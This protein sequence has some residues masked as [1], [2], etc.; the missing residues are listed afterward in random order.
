MIIK[1]L[2][3][4]WNNTYKLFRRISLGKVMNPDCHH[5]KSRGSWKST[6]PGPQN[7]ISVRFLKIVIL[8]LYLWYPVVR[9]DFLQVW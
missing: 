8:I 3:S 6:D 9:V 4:T 2:V 7:N 1:I 5:G